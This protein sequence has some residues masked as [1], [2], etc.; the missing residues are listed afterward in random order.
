[1]TAPRVGRKQRTTQEDWLRA[2]RTIGETIPRDVIE[3]RVER[4]AAEVRRRVQGRRAAYGW[5]GGK[6]SEA[7]RIVM[8]RAGVVPCVLVISELEFPEFLQWTTDNMPP[9]LEV[10]NTGQNLQWLRAHP[11]MLFPTEAAVAA[12]W[13]KAVQHTGQAR[14]YARHRLDLLCLGRRKADGNHVGP[15]GQNIYRQAGTGVVRYSPLA[16]WTHEEVLA[17]MFHLGGR[18]APC[19]HWPNGFKQGTGPWAARQWCGSV[20]GGWRECWTIDPSVVR[21]AAT[22]LPSAAAFVARMGG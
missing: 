8:E 22:V 14:Y 17:A 11:E 10:E 7:L 4:T 20:E 3:E 1:M 9:S 15:A 21:A 16:D 5:S 6:D 12:K 18:L 13:F 19:Y 2:L